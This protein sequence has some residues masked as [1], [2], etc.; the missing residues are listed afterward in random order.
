[1]SN[2]PNPV[3]P[4][5]PAGLGVAPPPVATTG[6]EVKPFARPVVQPTAEQLQAEQQAFIPQTAMVSTGSADRPRTKSTIT[7]YLYAGTQLVN[8]Q[9]RIVRQ[10]YDSVREAYTELRSMP[11]E[12]RVSL[13]N[14]MYQRGLY[15]KKLKPSA[16]GLEQRDL[17]VMQDILLASNTYGYDWRT[18]LNFIRQE[19]PVSSG[20]GRRLTSS[21]DLA[22]ALDQT[23]LGALGRTLTPEER[24]QQIAYI[25]GQ[26][27]AGTT[28]ST[29]T[30][31][32][33]APSRVN[34][35]EEQAYNFARV[36]D[37]TASILG[38]S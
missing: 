2:T 22:R 1:M 20:S 15:D 26:E 34:P 8:A 28:T 7:G 9:G 37:I 21:V 16:T 24:K 35:A 5:D 36:A 33:M 12:E 18:S 27:A 32:S 4:A 25:Q 14:E 3:N 17:R 31:V 6:K 10:Q 23:A 19:N 13:L 29:S 30:L 38:G 11:S